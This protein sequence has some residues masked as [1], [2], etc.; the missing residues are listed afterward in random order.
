M[1][2]ALSAYM[3]QQMRN[4]RLIHLQYIGNVPAIPA[5][6]AAVGMHVMYNWGSHTTIESIEQISP[7]WLLFTERSDEFGTATKRRHPETLIAAYWPK[8]QEA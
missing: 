8:N 2:S 6:E 7:P 1:T 4:A 3:R 5:E